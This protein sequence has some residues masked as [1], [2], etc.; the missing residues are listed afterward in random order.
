MICT[1]NPRQL[2]NTN[3]G[4]AAY[5]CCCRC[6]R[7]RHRCLRR[8]CAPGTFHAPHSLPPSLRVLKS[9][10]VLPRN[11]HGKYGDQKGVWMCAR[12]QRGGCEGGGLLGNLTFRVRFLGIRAAPR[13]R[14]RDWDLGW[15][16]SDLRDGAS[17]QRCPA[18]SMRCLA[19]TF[20]LEFSLMCF[21]WG[22]RGG[23]TIRGNRT[24]R[25]G[26]GTAGEGSRTS[27]FHL[28]IS[29]VPTLFGSMRR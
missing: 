1:C 22:V 14:G 7:R 26:E 8:L 18:H 3:P 29:P 5:C 11:F 21:I 4:P 9:A 16:V 23:G 19:Q 2:A 20:R 27:F 6:R 17:R 25:E 10:T 12:T 13:D 15:R 24:S 28:L